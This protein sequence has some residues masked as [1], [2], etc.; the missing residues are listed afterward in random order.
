MLL[1]QLRTAGP[2]S[3]DIEVAL[4]KQ[5][6]RGQLPNNSVDSVNLRGKKQACGNGA[7]SQVK[8]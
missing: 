4:V 7:I 3:V 1:K 5:R 6:T 2:D 8:R